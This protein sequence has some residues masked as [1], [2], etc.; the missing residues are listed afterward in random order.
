M[1]ESDLISLK[2][3]VSKIDLDS[4][5][6]YDELFKGFTQEFDMPI[7]FIPIKKESYCL[8]SRNNKAGKDFE[9]FRDLIYPDKIY[10]TKYSRANKPGQQVFYRS[11]NIETNITEL[12]PYWSKDMKSGETFAITVSRWI[13]NE[14]VYV[15]CIPDYS[16]ARLMTML[17]NKIDLKSDPVLREYW[18]YIN[19]FFRA[20]GFY[21][22]NVYKF[23]S[24]YCNALIHNSQVIKENVDGILYTSI[25]DSTGW[26]L[27][28]SPKFVDKNLE[29]ES[30]LK[31]YLRKRGHK[32]GKPVYDNF[33][34]PEPI[35]PKKL[36]FESHR[37]IW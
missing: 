28:I 6:A 29:L 9:D 32:N 8:R 2:S 18:E 30:V 3:F 20:Q 21:Q 1:E 23:T 14:Q 37:I 31:I 33:L 35:F 27:A 22:P 4:E 15:V 5:A 11:D 12:M 10:I 25:Q 17:E 16:N 36:D 7:I 24:A 13:F 26:N 34:N 19:L